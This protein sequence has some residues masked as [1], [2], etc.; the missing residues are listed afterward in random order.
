MS[1]VI[2]DNY[3]SF[4]FNLFQMLQPLVSEPIQVFR[5]DE[6]TFEELQKLQPDHVVMSPGPG[7]PGNDS[8]F[9]VCKDVIL[10]RKK[11]NAAILGV[12]LGHQGIVHHLGGKVIRAP[13]IIHGKTSKIKVKSQ[14]PLFDGIDEEFEAMRYHSLIA[15]LAT[16]PDEITVTAQENG[17]GLVM[18][19][20]HKTDRLYGVQFH[21]ESIGTPQGQKMLR[22]FVEKC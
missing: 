21:P 8:D 1:L 4:T 6:I 19:L 16:V 11:L 2:I 12:C 10:N 17:Q 13:Q 3:D 9:G 14:T 5:N 20:Q 7:H 18:A 15:D 22:N